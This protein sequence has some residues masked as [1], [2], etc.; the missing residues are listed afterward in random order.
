[1]NPM[2]P[3][4]LYLLEATNEG[5]ERMPGW[6]VNDAMIVRAANAKHAR[7]LASAKAID[8][9]ADTWTN[10]RY[11]TCKRIGEV[12]AGAKRTPGV[13]MTDDNAS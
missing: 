7:T 1:M 8:E 2:G 10:G 3:M 4:Y 9:P 13:I 11:S 6:E 5:S 12:T